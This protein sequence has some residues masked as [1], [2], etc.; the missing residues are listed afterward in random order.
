[1]SRKKW[2]L[3]GGIV[4]A[5]VIVLALPELPSLAGRTASQALARDPST[6]IAWTYAEAAEQHPGLTGIHALSDGRSAFAARMLLIEGAQRS[7]DVQY[8]IWHDDVTGHL[9]LD[10]LRRADARGV[11]VRLL[12]DDNGITGMDP[13]LAALDALPNT[14][15][16][17]YNPFLQRRFKALGYL[18]DFRRLNRRMHN[19]SLTAD[20]AATI[21]GGRNIGDEYFDAAEGVNFADLDLL[22]V[23]KVVTE[24]STVFDRYWN[25]ESAYPLSILIQSDAIDARQH[26]LQKLD[27]HGGRVAIQKYAAALKTSSLIKNLVSGQLAVEWVPVRLLADDPEKTLTH[28]NDHTQTLMLP[29]LGTAI[30]KAESRLDLVSPYF[31]PMAEGTEAFA[32]MARRDVH[33]RVLTNSL[34]ATDVSAVHAGYAKRRKA[35]LEAG[36]RLFELK[37]DAAPDTGDTANRGLGSSSASLHAK[38]FAVDGRRAFV[39][40]FNFDPRSAEFNTEM[41]FVVD[42]TVLATAIHSG[43]DTELHKGSYEVRL[44]ASGNLEWIDRSSGSEVVLHEEPETGPFKRA[45]VT[46]LSWLPI[47]IML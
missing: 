2:W 19:K 3:G 8:Y 34:A 12:L 29:R 4:L 9:L 15:V 33:I 25:S 27:A 5:A 22:A 37:P 39:G 13:V 16:R 14:E 23:G 42:S 20:N 43:F 24:V 41:G 26:I 10:A 35:L 28:G 6:P 11:R 1:M 31:V 45:L 32:N 46:V 40:S 17:L 47:D 18:T 7:L 21:I 30:G 38:T 44:D 36:V